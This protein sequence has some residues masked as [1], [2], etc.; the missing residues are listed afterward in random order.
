MDLR[1]LREQH[2]LSQSELARQTGIS[3]FTLINL[4]Q[5]K[6]RPSYE[7]LESL[8]AIF[9]HAV[10]EVDW[11]PSTP[12]KKRGRPSPKASKSEGGD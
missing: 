3:R 6:F 4:E 12:R 10:D 2:N 11:T 8:R 1:T 7:T 9:G 5:R